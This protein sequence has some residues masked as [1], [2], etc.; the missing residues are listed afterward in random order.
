M[1]AVII[2]GHAANPGDVSWEPLAELCELTVYERTAVCDVVS[3]CKDADAV[4]SNKVMFDGTNLDELGSL[5]YIGVLATGYNIVDMELCR[6]K[7]I[8]VTNIPG[9]ATKAVGQM[10]FALLL[11]LTHHVG[12]HSRGVHD[13][14]WSRSADFC[15]WDYPLVELNGKTMGIIG[16][17]DI[18]RSVARIARGFD[19]NVIAY[20]VD[21]GKI[22]ADGIGAVEM[23]RI[24]ADS[25]VLS[26][27]CP[28]TEDTRGLVNAKTLAKMKPSAFLINT[29][30]GPLVDEADL[31]AAL[32]EGVIAGAGIDV[33]SQEP[34]AKDNV[35]FSAKNCIIT[36]HIAW[37]TQAA[38][39][40]LI[41]IAAENLRGFIEGR[42]VNV[43]S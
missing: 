4:F 43:V 29:G 12:E 14:K 6:E 26:L 27:N 16:Y 19:M 1:K 2:D 33:L 3:R 23:E 17:G 40:R 24:F 10:V 7:G 28:L 21:K 35:L 11:E 9:Y 36:P 38:R 5:K 34:P 32:N 37:G 31:A 22:E 20:D 30:R 39:T 42:R 25:D 8:V 13:G 18:G 15:Y 41:D